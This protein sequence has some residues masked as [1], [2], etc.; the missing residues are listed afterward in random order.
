MKTHIVLLA[1]ALGST[2]ATPAPAAPRIA[3]WGL[4]LEYIDRSVKPGDDFYAY[5]NGLWL[6]T[7]V[8]PADRPSAG[9]G[10]EIALL[11]DE[12][13]RTIVA[14][15]KTRG[16][17]TP[18]EQKLRDLYQSF[19][20]EARIEAAGLKPIEKDLA[21][22]AA[23]KTHQDIARLIGRR[24][25]RL[26]G[27]FRFSIGA[28]DKHPE[29]YIVFIG[30]SGL[31]LPD[32]DYYLRDDKAIVSTREAYK[33]YLAQTLASVGVGAAEAETRAAA[34]YAMEHEIAVAHW[35]A[36]QRR[37]ADKTYNPIT[38]PALKSF[39]PDF[40]WEACFTS[41]EIPLQARGADRTVSIAEK[42]AFPVI[43]KAFRTASVATWRDYLTVRCV[44]AFAPYLSRRFD[45]ADFAFHGTILSGRTKQLDRATRAVRLLD[46]R[47]GEALGKIY[48]AK[49][50]PPES[51]A[52]VRVLVD[53]LLKAFDENLNTL[54]WMTDATRAKAREKRNKFT[55]KVGYPD[56]WRDY[57]TLAISR[58]DLVGNVKAANAFDWRREIERID[59][60]VDKSEWY[61]SPP[62]VNAYYDGTANEIVFPAGIL[63]S[64]Y[65]DAEA[66]DAVNYGS[67]GGTIGHEISHGFDD[68]GSK[69]DGTGT[70]RQWW[71]DADRKNFDDRTNVL[72]KQYEEYEP[73]P[74][75]R[76]NGRLTL[77]ENIGDL[78]GLTIAHKA[79]RISLGGKEAPVLDGLTGDQRFYIAYAQSWRSKS[80]DEVTRQRLL[81]NPHSPPAYRVIGIVRNDDGWYEAF[82]EISPKDKYYL[83]PEKRVRLW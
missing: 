10:L 46:N 37:D 43:A 35:P 1:A 63:Q 55:V 18:E 23:A 30:Q 38:I 32:R 51:K 62:T 11:N 3:P 8:I 72:V 44:H 27:P 66:D 31:G 33:K 28:D 75:I 71:T 59:G 49:Y 4:H 19:T 70:L 57:S 24:D 53:N 21:E 17:L 67:I 69:Y 36:D 78:S 9:G 2:L 76:I 48:V 5:A 81:S 13:L 61:M 15:L 65:F 26:G 22:I 25:L 80:R 12:R 56:R 79:Y 45:D 41:A 50:F 20:D 14:E 7:A 74:G 54:T 77:G 16:N 82:P 34:I 6:K 73:L 64:P 52:K 39:A 42:S 83:A 47:M 29:A 68:Q 58:D 40:P 60:P